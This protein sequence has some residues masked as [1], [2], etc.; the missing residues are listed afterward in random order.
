MSSPDSSLRLLLACSMAVLAGCGSGGGLGG[1]TRWGAKGGVQAVA[2]QP[3]GYLLVMGPALARLGPGGEFDPNFVCDDT[4]NSGSLNVQPDGAILRDD[5]KIHRLLRNGREDTSFRYEGGTGKTIESVAYKADG[6]VII[7]ELAPRERKL[8]SLR[9]VHVKADGSVDQVVQLTDIASWGDLAYFRMGPAVVHSSGEVSIVYFD[10][11][12]YMGKNWLIRYD[13]KGRLIDKQSRRLPMAFRPFGML[14]AH[15]GGTFFLLDAQRGL[16]A[17]YGPG[18][19]PERGFEADAAAVKSLD[20]ISQTAVETPAGEIYLAGTDWLVRL[21]PDGLM[22]RN[23]RCAFRGEPTALAYM[24]PRIVV[25]SGGK[26]S[27]FKEDG[28]PD[29]SFRIPEL[30]TVTSRPGSTRAVK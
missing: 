14:A 2:A 7:L 1:S 27:V 17:K 5:K 24:N 30:D 13:S 19:S 25:L 15:D 26:L 23:F 12:G 6:G 16:I 20:Q 11:E 22:D 21:R 8:S 28:S 3:G 9:V 29:P 4:D 18:G 10:A